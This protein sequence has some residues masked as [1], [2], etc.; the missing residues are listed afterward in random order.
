LIGSVGTGEVIIIVR[1]CR[2]GGDG[3]QK[4]LAILAGAKKISAIMPRAK[5]KPC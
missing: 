1:G 3:L 2:S 5:I 4:G